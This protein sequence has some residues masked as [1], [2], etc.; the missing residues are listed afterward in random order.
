M[1]YFDFEKV[2]GLAM[3]LRA[4]SKTFEYPI[5]HA[6]YRRALIIKHTAVAIVS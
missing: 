2:K 1:H 3:K 6:V 4:C 5:D